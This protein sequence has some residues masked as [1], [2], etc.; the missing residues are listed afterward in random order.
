MLPGIRLQDRLPSFAQ[1]QDSRPYGVLRI[2]RVL[3]LWSF[4]LS[5]RPRV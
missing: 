5:C 1:Q 4:M 2:A 3:G